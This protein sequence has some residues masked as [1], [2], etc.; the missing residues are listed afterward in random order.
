VSQ[1]QVPGPSGA[2]Q[3]K[4]ANANEKNPNC[5]SREYTHFA[6]LIAMKY[7]AYKSID[8]LK[9]DFLDIGMDG[10]V[11][12]CKDLCYEFMKS[13]DESEIYT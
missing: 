2:K 1:D 4:C 11:E 6:R 9:R 7:Y 12:L 5:P 8:M 13:F 10:Y 3:T